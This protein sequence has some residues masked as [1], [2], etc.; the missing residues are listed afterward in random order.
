MSMKRREFITL[1]GGAASLPLAARAQ[2]GMPLIGFLDSGARTGM[3]ANLAGFHRGL[4]ETQFT[5]GRNLAVEYRWAQGQYEQLPALAVELVLKPVAVIVASRGPAPGRAAKAAT[6]SIPVVFQTGTDP[7]S[8]GLVASLN[9]PEGN[10]TGATR[11]SVELNAKRL[12]LLKELVPRAAVVA[13]LVNMNSPVG[14]I[15]VQELQQPARALGIR[16]H[17]LT[18]SSQ[19]ELQSAFAALAPSGADALFVAND[20]QFIGWQRQIGELASRYAIPTILPEREYAVAGG[21]MSYG[22]SLSDSFR[23]VGHYVGRILKGAKPADL[24]VLQPV[25]F[26]LVINLKTAKALGLEI[27]PKLLFT[28]DEVIE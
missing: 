8:S 13:L 16:L 24:P 19:S 7:V 11:Q 26:E 22:A 1:I 20:P 4:A 18:A 17:L 15:N 25:K 14:P 27:P 10:V 12:G 3:D 6:A 2:L 23:Q 5:E 9:R 21:L 28:A